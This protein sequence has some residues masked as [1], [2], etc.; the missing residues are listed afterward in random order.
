MVYVRE[1]RFLDR[2]L[3]FTSVK[4]ISV[5]LRFTEHSRV[6]TRKVVFTVWKFCVAIYLENPREQKFI[7]KMIIIKQCFT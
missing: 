5:K 7:L 1:S 4:R 6:H 2:E 3:E